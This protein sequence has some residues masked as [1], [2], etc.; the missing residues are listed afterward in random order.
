LYF[1]TRPKTR[2]KDLFDREEELEL[3]S[4]TLDYASLIVITGLRRTGKTSFMNVALAESGYPHIS[5]D[6]RGL[7]YNPSRTEIVRRLEVAFKRIER[8]RLSKLREVLTTVK[9]VSF[10]GGEISFD[11]GKDGIDFVELFDKIDSWAEKQKSKFLV[12]FDELQLIRGDKSIP[13]LIAHVIDTNKNIITIVTGSEV[14]L[15]YGFLKFDSSDSPLY[16]RH[17]VDVKMSNFTSE[18]TKEFLL[19]GFRQIDISPQNDVISYAI[20]NLDG[21]V[22]WLTLFGVRCR[23][24][25]K[26]NKEM[27]DITLNQGGKLARDEV[28]PMITRSKR[29]GPILN[30]LARTG[31]ASWS[32]I[33][34][35][36]EVLERR[37]LPSST[38]TDTLNKLLEMSL[39]QTENGTYRIIDPILRHGITQKPIP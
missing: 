18:Q 16:G 13:R 22:G 23:D 25:K 19:E 31:G 24:I 9:G 1:E 36:L 32:Q 11:W 35:M 4:H 12:A 6:L 27:V 8:K 3:F 2:K 30:Y 26:C 33:K 14:G 5:L 34:N 21:I 37:S 20:E 28:V 7:S 10:P 15:L 39:V 38:F 29:Y 17:R